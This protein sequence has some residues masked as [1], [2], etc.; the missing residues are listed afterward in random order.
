MPAARSNPTTEQRLDRIEL[1]IAQ[2][3]HALRQCSGWKPEANGQ[4][5]LAEICR[6][7]QAQVAR[8]GIETRPSTIADESRAA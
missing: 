1:G 3:A 8:A 4:K 7:A 5:T 2:L 6:D